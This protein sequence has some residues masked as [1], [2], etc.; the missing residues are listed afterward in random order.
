MQAND[1]KDKKQDI[2][3]GDGPK[4]SLSHIKESTFRIMKL[5]GEQIELIEPQKE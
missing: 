2:L 4:K 5:G 3:C 1:R